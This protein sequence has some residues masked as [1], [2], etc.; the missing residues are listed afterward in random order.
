MIDTFNTEADS[1]AE[2]SMRQLSQIVDE[3]IAFNTK[4]EGMMNE[5]SWNRDCALMQI[6]AF[7]CLKLPTQRFG[8]LMASVSF[9]AVARPE[10]LEAELKRLERSFTV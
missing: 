6:T 5:E 2:A 9:C 10:H 1:P 8:E 4:R 3:L 7:L